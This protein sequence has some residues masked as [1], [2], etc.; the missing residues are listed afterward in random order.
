MVNKI[1]G[2]KGK[3]KTSPIWLHYTE[4]IA[5]EEVDDKVIKKVMAKCK[6]CK[7][8][9]EAGSKQGTSCLWNHY[10]AKHKVEKS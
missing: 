5:E 3:K 4:I 7:K 6:Y 1:K 10:K 2:A 8:V 9:L